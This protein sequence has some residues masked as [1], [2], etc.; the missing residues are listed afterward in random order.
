MIDLS[1]I[2]ENMLKTRPL[3]GSYLDG[4]IDQS[5]GNS[6]EFF[7]NSKTLCLHQINQNSWFIPTFLLQF[8]CPSDLQ[9]V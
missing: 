8:L 2:I 5:S 7:F 6:R 1:R 3:S 4:I 9:A